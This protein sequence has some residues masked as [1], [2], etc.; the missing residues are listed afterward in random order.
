MDKNIQ[1]QDEEYKNYI[2]KT[3]EEYNNNGKKT[4]AYMCDTYYPIVDGV[5]KVMENYAV[6]ISEHYNVVMIVPKHKN[7]EIVPHE[8]FLVIGISG[9]YFKFVN[10]DLAFPEMDS[11]LKNTLKKLR[12]DIIHCHSPFNVGSFAAKLAKKRNIPFVMTMHSQYKQ[13][14]L[15]YTKSE[16]LA[17]MLTKRICRVFNKTTEVWTMHEKASQTLQS[18]GYKGNNF[19]YIRNATDYKVPNNPDKLIEELNK[20]YNISPDE[21]VFLFVGRLVNQKNIQFILEGLNILNNKGIN[22]KMF[23]V[24]DGPDKKELEENIKKFN[25]ENKV[26]LTGLIKS[27]EELS[28]YYQRA[29]LFLFPSVYDTSSIVQIESACFK[30]PAVFVKDTVTACGVKHNHSGYLCEENLESFTETIINAISDKENLNKVSETAH[31]ELYITWDDVK[32]QAYERYEY[33]IEENKKKLNSEE[34]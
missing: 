26:Y 2:E 33:L 11:Y 20:D 8:K 3:I 5:I 29:N 16:P 22:F 6:K 21:P 12:I 7:K 24:G 23:F 28:K 30:T 19:F 9:M 13:D 10:Y 31:K 25:L 4:I 18:Y 17:K 1:L 14:F 27:R 15:K 32:K 34:K